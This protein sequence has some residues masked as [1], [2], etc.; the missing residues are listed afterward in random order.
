MPAPN[1]TGVSQSPDEHLTTNDPTSDVEITPDVGVFPEE[2][3]E[4]ELDKEDKEVEE[5]AEPDSELE[6]GR[7]DVSYDI[8]ENICGELPDAVSDLWGEVT[9]P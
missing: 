5:E 4:D 2:M 3:L 6:G 1:Q 9:N 7:V 8:N